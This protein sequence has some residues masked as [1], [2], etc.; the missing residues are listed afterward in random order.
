MFHGRHGGRQGG[1]EKKEG[2][3]QFHVDQYASDSLSGR[4]W[5]CLL[6]SKRRRIAGLAFWFCSCRPWVGGEKI[7]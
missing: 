2:D 7:L 3:W 1:H 4:G 5:S 6:G